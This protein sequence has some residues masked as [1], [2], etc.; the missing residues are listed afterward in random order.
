[1]LNSR[2]KKQL[3][4]ENYSSHRKTGQ[5]LQNLY[6]HYGKKVKNSAGQQFNP[7]Q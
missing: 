2:G 1:M 3:K 7:Y 6:W 5:A 4:Y